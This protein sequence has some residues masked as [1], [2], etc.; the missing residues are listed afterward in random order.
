MK[1]I[2]LKS[3]QYKENYKVACEKKD[4]GKKNFL[5]SCLSYK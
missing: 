2:F 4:F 1:Y 3:V 5:E